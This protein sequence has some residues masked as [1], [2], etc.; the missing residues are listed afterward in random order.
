MHQCTNWSCPGWYLVP[1]E[2]SK[3]EASLQAIHEY[4]FPHFDSHF[5]VD[6]L[7]LFPH[8]RLGTRVSHLRSTACV[9]SLSILDYN[10]PV[11]MRGKELDF[12][13]ITYLPQLWVWCEAKLPKLHQWKKFKLYLSDILKREPRWLELPSLLLCLSLLSLYIF[14]KLIEILCKIYTIVY[15]IICCTIFMLICKQKWNACN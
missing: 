13:V 11:G 10:F 6:I 12:P 5:G 7:L 15:M 14:I 2:F 9:P 1:Q 3:G 8:S 4:I